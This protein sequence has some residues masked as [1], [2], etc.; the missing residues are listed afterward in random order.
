MLSILSFLANAQLQEGEFYIWYK[1]GALYEGNS[2]I[3]TQDGG[4]GVTGRAD[5]TYGSHGHIYF[6]KLDASGNLT[7]SKLIGGTGWDNGS[8]IVQTRNGGYTIAGTTSSYGAGQNDV[9]IVNLDSTGNLNW[10]KTIGG[11]GNDN[12][13][14]IITTK[15]GGY[16]VAGS[17][18]SFGAGGYDVF[19]LKLDSLGTLNWTKTIGGSGDDNGISIVGTKDGGFAIAGST[20]SYGAGQNDVYV[21]KLDSVGNLKWTKTI[22]GTTADYGNSLVQTQDGGYI[23]TGETSSY[24]AGGYDVYVV[25]LDSTGSLKWTKTIGRTGDDWGYSIVQS[26]DSSF[27]IVGSTKDYGTL[28]SYVY[29]IKLDLNGNLIWAKELAGQS[30]TGSGASSIVQ[31]KDGGYA[32]TGSLDEDA[33][34]DGLL[35][36][37]KLDSLG[38]Q[39]LSVNNAGIVNSGGTESSGGIIGNAGGITISDSGKISNGGILTTLCK[40]F[41][42]VNNLMPYRND[43]SIYPNPC[44]NILHIDF[45]N[46]SNLSSIQITDIIGRVILTNRCQ[47]TT[48]YYSIDVSTLAQG[49]YFMRINSPTRTEV[50]KFIKE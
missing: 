41:T 19:V 42:S 6:G 21:I 48:N 45:E 29:C 47:L 50:K 17:T 44:S 16:I 14:S 24:G 34:G 3:Q 11:T 20:S 12:G 32:L 43:I 38:N 46:Q 33:M 40:T 15:D 28:T 36:I 7:L 31:T 27:L 9:Y 4:Y 49:M 25:R 37:T 2:I 13:N 8:S 35:F 22:G 10:S 5:T 39:C 1:I 26:K 30:R 23:I 18:N